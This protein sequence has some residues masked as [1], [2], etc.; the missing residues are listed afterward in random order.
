M[1][2]HDLGEA[3]IPNR[4]NRIIV[5]DEIMLDAIL[6]LGIKPIAVGKPDLVSSKT[7]IL[8][9]KLKELSTIGKQ[10]QPNLEKIVKLNPDLIIGFL[11][12]QENYK[13]LSQIAPTVALEYNQSTWKDAL[14]RIGE[15]VGEQEKAEI[16]LNQYQQRLTKLRANLGNK[17]TKINV[18]ISR[19][20]G[21]V[22]SPE[23]RSKFSFP[24]SILDEIGISPPESQR[25]L[26]ATPDQNLIQLSIE[27]LDLLDANFL[28]V[29]VDPGAKD[30]FE[31]YQKTHMWQ[32]LNVVKNQR[33]Y[34]VDSSYWI[35][36]NIQS[37]N[38]IVNDL[39]KYLIDTVNVQSKVD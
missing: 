22:Q 29:A 7:S 15:I 9:T 11:I 28:F 39:F 1:I 37:A 18:S 25:Q 20:H 8:G 33:V 5:S 32:S 19:F 21:Q 4:P 26:I 17:L 31:K 14:R 10:S 12:S 30:L 6:A 36:G 24:G 34:I 27:K 35:F 23:F 2:K 13:L 3:C 38:A 16:L